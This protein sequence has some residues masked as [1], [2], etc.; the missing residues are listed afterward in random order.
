MGGGACAQW[1]ND[2]LLMC[3]LPVCSRWLATTVVG[4]V[5]TRVVLGSCDVPFQC[6]AFCFMLHIAFAV[7]A[8]HKGSH[9]NLHVL[10]IMVF[11]FTII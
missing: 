10:I 9:L 3:F 6:R 4:C 1:L 11:F 5:T 7:P 2:G 8:E